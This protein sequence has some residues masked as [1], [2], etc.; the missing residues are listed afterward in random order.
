MQRKVN[1]LK[2]DLFGNAV[3]MRYVARLVLDAV[4]RPD[5]NASRVIEVCV[6]DA[7]H[8]GWDD[9]TVLTESHGSRSLS[10]YQVKRQLTDLSKGELFEMLRALERNRTLTRATLF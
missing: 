8:E 9:V 6:E 3:A 5:R 4:G 1:L 2:S 7:A 10:G